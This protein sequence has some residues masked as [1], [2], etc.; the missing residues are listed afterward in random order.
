MR[1]WR[2]LRVGVAYYVDA[3][4]SDSVVGQLLLRA[5][6]FFFFFFHCSQ[7]RLSDTGEVFRSTVRSSSAALLS[8]CCGAATLRK[9]LVTA[10]SAPYGDGHKRVCTFT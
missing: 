1:A 8:C 3:A 4:G 2:R 9:R 5:M 10:L 6:S 7:S